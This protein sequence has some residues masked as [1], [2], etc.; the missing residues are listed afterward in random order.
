MNIESLQYQTELSTTGG[1]LRQARKKMGLSQQAVAERLCL[2]VSTIQDIEQGYSNPNLAATFLHGYIRSYAKLVHLSEA[3][4][5]PITHIQAPIK[6]STI[7]ST[8][9]F[10]MKKI[11][12]KYGSWLMIL[13][14]LILFVIIGLVLTCWKQNNQSQT[15]ILTRVTEQY[16]SELLAWEEIILTSQ[17][18]E[19]QSQKL[20]IDLLINNRNNTKLISS[21]NISHLFKIKTVYTNKYSL[22]THSTNNVWLAVNAD[23]K[24]LFSNAIRHIYGIIEINLI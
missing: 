15:S 10:S 8:Q 17:S 4:L 5:V 11:S 2:K 12:Q 1:R 23:Y 18:D 7:E 21:V 19:T 13:A 14:W 3:E 24:K 6:D 22:I 20:K 16:S 9:N